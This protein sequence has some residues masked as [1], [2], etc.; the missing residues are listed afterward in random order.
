MF[1]SHVFGGCFTVMYVCMYIYICIYF[2]LLV[3]FIYLV[4]SLFVLMCCFWCVVHFSCVLDIKQEHLH[5]GQ[6]KEHTALIH[7]WNQ[8]HTN[9]NT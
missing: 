8:Q 6:Y 7:S 2:Y 9:K 1:S 3:S 5:P 4:L